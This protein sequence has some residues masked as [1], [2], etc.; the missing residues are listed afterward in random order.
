MSPLSVTDCERPTV[1]LIVSPNSL[2]DTELISK[3]S[4]PSSS[5]NRRHLRKESAGAS[6]VSSPPENETQR[7][8]KPRSLL[9]EVL[10]HEQITYLN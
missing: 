9:E 6:A 8:Y 10:T 3:R 1:T 7:F 5:S 2:R 4:G